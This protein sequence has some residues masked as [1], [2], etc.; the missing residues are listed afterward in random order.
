MRLPRTP[1]STSRLAITRSG[2][3]EKRSRFT[4]QPAPASRL[5]DPLREPVGKRLRG[6]AP[7]VG[8]RG[9]MARVEQ[10]VCTRIHHQ[11]R[12]Y[13]GESLRDAV[14]RGHIQI[15]VETPD[16]D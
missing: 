8:Q 16:I 2:E 4:L 13:T 7:C 11:K 10:P 1:A 6:H 14:A 9:D 12:W 15:L 5:A 3:R